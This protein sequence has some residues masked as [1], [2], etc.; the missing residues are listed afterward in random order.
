MRSTKAFVFDHVCHS[1]TCTSFAR[2]KLACSPRILV[3]REWLFLSAC[4]G[5][6]FH[7]SEVKIW[8]Q[9]M[10]FRQGKPPLVTLHIPLLTLSAWERGCLNDCHFVQDYLLRRVVA[11]N[12]IP[13]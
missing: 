13:M 1:F 12:C 7:D 4:E 9:S 5:H 10:D 6:G 3:R 11:E 2:K 8:N